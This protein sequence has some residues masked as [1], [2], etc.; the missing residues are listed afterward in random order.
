MKEKKPWIV[1]SVIVIVVVGVIAVVF[2]MRDK[3]PAEE[4]APVSAVNTATP[5]TAVEPAPTATG[6][7]AET[8]PEESAEAVEPAPVEFLGMVTFETG[9]K[10]ERT[11]I[12]GVS[13]IAYDA[14][15]DLYYVLSDDR[16]RPDDPRFYTVRIAPDGSEVTFEAVTFLVEADG[17]PV[18]DGTYDTEGLVLWN[19]T[20]FISSE[21]IA[22]MIPAMDPGISEFT[23]AGE[24][25]AQFTLP[26]KFLPDGHQKTGIRDNK[27][28][29]ALTLSPDGT[30]LTTAVENALVQDGPAAT[31]EDESLSR[32]IQ[33]D[34][35]TM[36]PTAEYV[37]VVGRIPV[38]ATT[39]GDNGLPELIALDNDG[40]YLALERSYVSGFGNTIQLFL[41]S[42]SGATDVSGMDAL[43]DAETNE[44]LDFVPM[45]KTLLVNL[46]D[47]DIDPDNIEGMALGPMLEDGRQVLVLVS[48]NNF[49]DSQITQFIVLAIALD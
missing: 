49:N 5:A 46:F 26:E 44:P 47:L 27:S 40:N 48:D 41:T 31:Y 3:S 30:I 29:E 18:K 6:A 10:F 9:T 19:G 24:H 33:F 21:G 39:S 43:W 23:L 14:K 42:T 20:L 1:L 8:M 28:L 25:I 32:L 15:N 2:V 36:L 12:G 38:D 11:E 45:E 17:K 22:G 16:G 34:F 35:A 4:A 37:Y 7:A 13:A